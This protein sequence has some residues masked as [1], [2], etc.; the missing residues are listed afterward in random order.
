MSK[1]FTLTYLSPA[2]L[3]WFWTRLKSNFDRRANVNNW[4]HKIWNIV[5]TLGKTCAAA[6]T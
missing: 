2:P 6:K 5:K 3:S 1:R 4:R